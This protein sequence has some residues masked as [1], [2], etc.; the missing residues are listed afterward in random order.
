MPNFRAAC[1]ICVPSGKN[2]A[3]T[4][5][6]LTRPGVAPTTT[7]GQLSLSAVRLPRVDLYTTI[8]KALRHFTHDTLVHLGRM[9]AGDADD[10]QACLTQLDDLLNMLRS[11][12]SHENSFIHAAIEQRRPGATQRVRDDHDAHLQTINDLAAEAQA[13]RA[14]NDHEAAALRLYRH[15]ALFVAENFEHMH[16]EETSNNA[17]LWAMFS[18]AELLDLHGRLLASIPMPEMAVAMR[19]MASALTVKELHDMLAGMHAGMPQ[20]AFQGVL[21]LVQ[22]HMSTQRWSRLATYLAV[23]QVPGL[24]EMAQQ[25]QPAHAA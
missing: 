8:H 17:L 19:W 9:D 15:L 25:P 22:P 2:T 18:D 1:W 12:L 21:N 20:E 6:T 11:H 13:L 23:A 4:T 10:L 3:M 24:V 7:H 14:T 5:T 16:V